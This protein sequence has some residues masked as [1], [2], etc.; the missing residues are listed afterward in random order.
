MLNF[1]RNNLIGSIK[2]QQYDLAKFGLYGIY[3]SI[4]E[5]TKLRSRCK[6]YKEE[7]NQVISF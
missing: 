7:K 6:Q 4:T 5:G 2:K 1:P 3:D